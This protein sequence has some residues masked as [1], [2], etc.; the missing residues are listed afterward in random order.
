MEK[1]LIAEYKPFS[2]HVGRISNEPIEQFLQ[3][4]AQVNPWMIGIYVDERWAGSY[5][6]LGRALNSSY[7]PIVALGTNVNGYMATKAGAE[8]A[9]TKDVHEGQLD[10]FT[11]YEATDADDPGITLDRVFI[12]N[13]DP[14]TGEVD[15][16]K[17][18]KAC[19][20]IEDNSA[21]IIVGGGYQSI[22]DEDIPERANA[23]MIGTGLQN[24][25]GPPR[26]VAKKRREDIIAEI[27][28]NKHPDEAERPPDNP[29]VEDGP[30][31]ER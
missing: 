31:E 26:R 7:W 21:F 23:V 10:Q 22:E 29:F 14:E 6:L 11:I 27:W 24:I 2:P 17:A 4:I 15:K 12:N 9:L 16:E 3:R 20:K 1:L 25:Q 8:W 19:E 18:K 5:A 13:R 28:G 30:Y